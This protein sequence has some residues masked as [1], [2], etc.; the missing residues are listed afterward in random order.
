MEGHKWYW[1]KNTYPKTKSAQI[2]GRSTAC[3]TIC[4]GKE[5]GKHQSPTL[6]ALFVLYLYIYIYI[7]DTERFMNIFKQWFSTGFLSECCWG[8]G[9]G[10][11]YKAFSDTKMSWVCVRAPG[12]L[13]KDG[14]YYA[15]NNWKKPLAN[16]T[17]HIW[18]V[19]MSSHNQTTWWRHQMETFSAL[20]AICAGNSPVPGEFP[21]KGQW[22]G[23]LMFSLMCAE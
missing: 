14:L 19:S 3:S 1:L 23:A 22:R 11:G 8:G 20:L 6:L 7:V 13:G 15:L 18:A 21:H 9:G 12:W 16:E 2:T 10:G 17:L 4:Q 5:Q